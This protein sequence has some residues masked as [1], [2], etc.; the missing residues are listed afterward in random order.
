LSLIIIRDTREKENHGW[1]FNETAFACEHTFT[2]TLK[3]GDYTVKGCEDEIV[4]ER[5]A[6]VA[7]FAKSVVKESFNKELKR[8]A[9][10]PHAFLIFEFSWRQIEVFPMGSQIPK[11]KWKS[12]RVR[13]KY[14]LS[15]INTYR[16]KYGIHVIACGN[17]VFAQETAYKLL[18]EV[19]ENRYGK[20]H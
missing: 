10:F 15:C 9:E 4:I 11:F 7:E 6:T 20:L 1:Y 18:K 19:Y 17:A 12:V 14:M 3:T 2:R 5:K 13:G 8:M 16:I